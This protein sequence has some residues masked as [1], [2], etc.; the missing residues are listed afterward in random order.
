MARRLAHEIKNPLT[1]IQ[2]AVEEC[3]RRYRGDD[4][5]YRKMLDTTKDIVIEEVESLRR[6]VSEFAA[7]ARLPRAA[8]GEGDLGDFL[9]EQEPR[10]MREQV[11]DDDEVELTIEIE[12]GRL[13]VAIDRTMLY[14]VLSNLVQNGV[15]A[16]MSD[17]DSARVRIRATT[18]DGSCVLEVEDDGPGIPPK[19]GNKV[20][21]PYVTTKQDGSG[22][23]L[24][25]VKKIVIDHG[26]QIEVG[27]STLGGARFIITLPALG[28]EA[29]FAALARSEAPLRDA[30]LR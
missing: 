5:G 23:G 15:Q 29:S 9:R 13:P 4:A 30:D 17:H 25:I 27:E 10:L 3:H 7:F 14:R 11:A 21:D 1:P 19:L 28:S 2:L 20:F 16:A 12:E 18:S 6:L 26:G 22:L 24:T 8:L